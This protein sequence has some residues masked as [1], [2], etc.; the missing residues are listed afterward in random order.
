VSPSRKPRYRLLIGLARWTVLWERLWPGLWPAAAVLGVFLGLALLDV[1]PLLPGPLHILILL[2]F[3]AAL[4]A[5]AWR[6]RLS[7]RRVSDK[8]ARHRLEMDSDLDHRPLTALDD[9]LDNKQS[10]PATLALWQAHLQRMDRAVRRLRLSPPSPG[11]ARHDPFA[12]RAAV[13][14]LLVIAVIAGAGDPTDRLARALVPDLNGG[15]LGPV[16]VD[17]WVTPPAY[18]GRA[19]L[20]L[21][22]EKIDPAGPVLEIP[23]GSAVLAQVGG[24]SKP[25][26]LAVGKQSVEFTGIGSDPTGGGHRAKAI[27][28]DGDHLAVK[29][30]R[31]VLAQ[32]PIRVVP[33]ALPTIAFTA[34][35]SKTERAFLRIQ[36]E[37]G[38][39]YG[40][41]GVETRISLSQDAVRSGAGLEAE[42]DDDSIRLNLPL[43]E[44]GA[45]KIAGDSVNDLSSH[46]WAGLPVLVQLA[47]KDLGGQKGLSE[48]VKMILPERIFNHP[49]ARAIIEERKKLVDPSKEVL[50]GVIEALDLLSRRPQHFFEDKVVFLALRVALSRLGYLQIPVTRKDAAITSVQKLLWD[51][52][53][54]IEDGEYTIAER[55]LREL[56]RRL[57]EAFDR[58]AEQ[59]EIDRLMDQLQQALNEFLQALMEQFRDQQ[60][61][62]M[63]F[64]PDAQ[65]MD[66]SE[67][68]RMID[69]ARE[70]ARS[71]NMEAARR[72][73]SELR[74][75]MDR[76]AA[77]MRPGKPNE[78]MR[79][80][81]RLMD[82]LR[83]LT[84]QQRKL[85]EETFRKL[86]ERNAFQGQGRGKGNDKERQ[87]QGDPDKS[88]GAQ[89]ALRKQL[90]D[91]MLQ[92][93]DLMGGIPGSLGKAERAMR[94]A[95]RALD[96]GRLGQAM[97][98]QSEALDQLQQ[99]VEGM[100]QQMAR[101]MGT[102][103]GMGLMFG[104]GQPMGRR[105]GRGIGR[106]PLGRRT[107]SE[108]QNG[109]FS[110]GMVKIP[111]KMDR[112]RS[113]EIM[114]ELRR[115]SGEAERPQLERDYIDRLLKQF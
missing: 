38:D 35:P 45:K 6:F 62:P 107:E 92:F 61:K 50:A 48:T 72:M 9:T 102:Q 73:L 20:F 10:D 86:R 109:S 91:L 7:I 13:M 23:K 63:P 89:D 81:M 57:M 60:M 14:L 94:D 93:S 106:D 80:A 42:G 34:P 56:Q 100:S 25:P 75:M 74:K 78:A 115:R 19:P 101:Q 2:L 17:V 36:Y 40:L 67:L 29:Q 103:P 105:Q 79:K 98:S 47:A 28:E 16:T 59:S 65:I 114:R 33:D 32:W 88:G 12:L 21:N 39:D 31:R 43:A 110:E 84:D 55:N 76:M 64:D 5:A 95:A 4:A 44:P 111:D 52:A 69:E 54:R 27:I 49:V 8:D 97:P 26:S 112:L 85:L 18:T 51:T 15:R 68:Q 22:L 37:A 70:L 87:Q 53:L 104:R 46:P 71:G 77:G 90:G 99:A 41:A 83:K 58:N 1:L 24:L 96:Q 113:R 3:A 11:L 30:G 82:G 66:S 108:G